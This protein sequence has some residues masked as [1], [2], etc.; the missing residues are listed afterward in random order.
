MLWDAAQRRLSR[1]SRDRRAELF[2]AVRDAEIAAEISTGRVKP[3]G[4]YRLPSYLEPERDADSARRGLRNLAERF[5]AN[6]SRTATGERFVPFS[7]RE[8]IVH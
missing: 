7:E 1:E 4:I 5:G 2:V 6:V 3:R 8:R